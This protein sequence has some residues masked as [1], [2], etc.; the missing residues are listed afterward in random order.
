LQK[1]KKKCYEGRKLKLTVNNNR[2]EVTTTTHHQHRE[3][4]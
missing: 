2:K 3:L 4:H 1:R